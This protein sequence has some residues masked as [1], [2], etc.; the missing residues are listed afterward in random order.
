VIAP[1]HIVAIKRYSR[2]SH[3]FA[4]V[5]V[6][7]RK[8]VRTKNLRDV[9]DPPGKRA[10]IIRRTRRQRLLREQTLVY[11]LGRLWK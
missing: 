1:V 10:E 3:K 6:A 2:G 11:E 5:S 7:M 9:V 4:I 8:G